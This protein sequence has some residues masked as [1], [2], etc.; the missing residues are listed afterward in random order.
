M[1]QPITVTG[2]EADAILSAA[3]VA[4]TNQEFVNNQLAALAKKHFPNDQFAKGTLA[5]GDNNQ[6]I[7]KIIPSNQPPKQG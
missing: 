4:Q 3:K 1:N 5:W 6:W 7:V 2:P